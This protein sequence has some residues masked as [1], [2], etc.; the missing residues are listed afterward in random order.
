MNLLK[1]QG[2]YG[3]QLGCPNILGK[4]WWDLEQV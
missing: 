3:K 4:N 1:Y 2:K